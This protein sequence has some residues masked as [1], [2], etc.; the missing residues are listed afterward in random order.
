MVTVVIV[1][2]VIVTIRIRIRIRIIFEGHFI[3][4]FEYSNICAHHWGGSQSSTPDFLYGWLSSP[5]R[6]VDKVGSGPS[7][8]SSSPGPVAVVFSL[9]SSDQCALCGAVQC[10]VCSEH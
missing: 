1:T 2:V 3:R 9:V 7:T 10:S 6:D 5:A 8:G 4:I